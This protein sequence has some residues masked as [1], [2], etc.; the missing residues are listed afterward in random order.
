VERR[1]EVSDEIASGG[2]RQGGKKKPFPLVAATRLELYVL[3]PVLTAGVVFALAAAGGLT[4]VER[5]ANRVSDWLGASESVEASVEGEPLH[6]ESELAEA[7]GERVNQGFLRACLDIENAAQAVDFGGLFTSDREG[8]P[9][10][11]EGLTPQEALEVESFFS[12]LG[13]LWLVLSAHIR[14]KDG[15]W[16]FGDNPFVDEPDWMTVKAKC[17]EFGVSVVTPSV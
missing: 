6:S 10:W 5:S 13:D 11:V 8:Y 7:S 2:R 12:E 16:D 15:P 4:A 3:F 1:G 9:T 17:S 14:E